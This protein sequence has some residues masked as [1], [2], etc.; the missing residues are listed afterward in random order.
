M[1]V[2]PKIRLVTLQLLY[3]SMCLKSERLAASAR[4][5]LE[6]GLDE[7]PD[8]EIIDYEESMEGYRRYTR[9]MPRF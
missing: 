6:Q 4:K 9:V 1:L 2:T 7:M 5:C 3:R 8:A